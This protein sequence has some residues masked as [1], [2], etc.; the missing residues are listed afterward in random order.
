MDLIKRGFQLPK[1][2]EFLEDGLTERSG[3][4]VAEPLE[5][6]Y[7]T[8][9]GNALRRVLLSSLEGAAITT[10]RI[11]GVLHEF[12]T[13]PG[14]K[15]DVVDIILNVKQIRL[16]V[17]ADGERRLT[18]KKKGP[19]VVTAGD[20][21]TD[22]AVEILNPELPIAT[23]DKEAD[24]EMELTVRKGRGFVPAEENKDE[25]H[26]I[27][28]IAVDSIF[29][30]VRMANFEVEKA[31]VG[32]STDYDRL[33]MDIETDGSLTP[34]DALSQAASILIEHLDLFN[35]NEGCGGDEDPEEIE[36]EAPQDENEPP[37][38]NEHLLKPVEEL[39]LSVRSYNCL[40]NAEIQTI[41][42]LVQ[43]SEQEMLKTKNFGR[44]SLTEIRSILKTMG[45]RFG[46]RVD[47]EAVE[48]ARAK[49]QAGGASD[50]A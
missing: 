18:L 35:L 28:V 41:G 47:L 6:G 36:T 46:M 13:V 15:E 26:P 45:L 22:S 5:R 23:L 50:A 38:F 42:D 3:R 4:L 19:G 40:K 8:T 1:K 24:L 12:D 39:E 31:R 32:R 37:V 2:L 16:R 20:I 11:P 44:K 9:I 7:G 21:E 27:D 43:R 34:Q 29:T 48:A 33:Y 49:M 30:P 14:V 25:E 17:H 10:I